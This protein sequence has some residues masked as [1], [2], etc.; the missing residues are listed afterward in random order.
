MTAK[1]II[2]TNFLQYVIF[3]KI[4][5]IIFYLENDYFT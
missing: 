5:N 2:Y 4:A 1:C 3:L